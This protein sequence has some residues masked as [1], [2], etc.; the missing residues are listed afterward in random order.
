MHFPAVA[1]IVSTVEGEVNQK[2]WALPRLEVLV[3]AKVLSVVWMLVSLY[4]NQYLFFGSIVFTIAQ[5]FPLSPV[6]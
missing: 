4:T 6:E 1:S 2:R 5:D 3:P